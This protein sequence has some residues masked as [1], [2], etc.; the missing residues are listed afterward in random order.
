MDAS[1][2]GTG[3]DNLLTVPLRCLVQWRGAKMFLRQFLHSWT[4]APSTTVCT[5]CGDG[6]PW[7]R[8]SQQSRTLVHHLLRPVAEEVVSG[9]VW[10]WVWPVQVGRH[11]RRGERHAWNLEGGV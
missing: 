7:S 8:G 5:I 11:G 2:P 1:G 6:Q 3:H 9:L 4:N 10:C